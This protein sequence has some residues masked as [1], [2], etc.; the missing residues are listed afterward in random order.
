MSDS[1]NHNDRRKFLG[2]SGKVGLSTMVASAAGVNLGVVDLVQ[3]Q[4]KAVQP[5]RFAMISDSH[6]YSGPDH[7]FDRQ[8]EDAIEQVNDMAV[9]P[10][11]VIYGGDIA[12]NGTDDQLVKG[13]KILS[14][15]KA[16]MVIIPGEHDWYVDLGK[17]WQGHYGGFNPAS[18]QRAGEKDYWS[19]DHKGVHFIGMNSILVK[20]FWTAANLTPKQR[21]EYMEML[22]G[23]W[24]GLW[25]VQAH[26]LEWL[27]KDVARLAP[28]TPVVVF[29][30][31]PLWDYYPRWNFQ[32]ADA[33]EIRQILSKF[34]N[35]MSFHGHV[36]QT[37]YNKIGNMSSIGAMSTSWPWPYPPVTLP[38]PQSQMYRAD[39]S[40]EV[41]G[42]GTLFA[43]V[44]SPKV[45]T[46]Q[47]MPMADSLTPFMKNGF[48][49]GV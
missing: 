39:P 17:A 15:L 24:A 32:T 44:E 11:F 5:F 34:T 2:I 37:L 4:S 16:K 3:A 40:N 22:E 35:V 1:M 29:T 12:Q 45:A 43:Q 46:V 7:K 30:H 27:K 36:H 9:Q 26:Q 49:V 41:D 33:P 18:G 13:K 19:F 28:D 31:S 38:F 6:L 48:K 25:G 47:H 20:D 21:M 10:D 8:L 42:M 23:P 14:K